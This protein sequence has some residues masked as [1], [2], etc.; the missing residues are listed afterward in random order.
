MEQKD[1]T[2][3][4]LVYANTTLRSDLQREIDRFTQLEAKFREVLIKYNIKVKENSRNQQT[5]FET[6]TGA[7]ISNFESFIDDKGEFGK[8]RDN[9]GNDS[10]GSLNDYNRSPQKKRMWHL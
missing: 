1:Q 10:D 9:D 5:L 2:I 7:Q 8:R 4:K 6:A 3:K